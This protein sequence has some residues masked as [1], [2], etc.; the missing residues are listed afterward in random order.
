M[1][2]RASALYQRLTQGVSQAHP[3]ERVTKIMA[4]LESIVS[5]NRVPGALRFLGQ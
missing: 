3:S 1:T 4:D 5:Q 2:Y